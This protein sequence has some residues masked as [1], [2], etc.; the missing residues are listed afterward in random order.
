MDSSHKAVTKGWFVGQIR[1]ILTSVGLPQHD[2]AGH[3]FRIGAATT[4]A[5]AGVD[6]S[7]AW[8]V[9]QLSLPPIHSS[10][11]GTIGCH[12]RKIGMSHFGPSTLTE[13]SPNHSLDLRLIVLCLVYSAVLAFSVYV[14]LICVSVLVIDSHAYRPTL[15]FWRVVHP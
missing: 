8:L 4:A 2:F 15:R 10:A 12:L 1:A 9:A 6:D 14:F 11:G 5:L 7:V 3:S 13:L